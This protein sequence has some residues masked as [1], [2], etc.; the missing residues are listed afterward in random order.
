VFVAAPAAAG[1]LNWKLRGDYSYNS[2]ATCASASS[3]F[4][5]DLFFP[6]RKGTDG[7][8]PDATHPPALG[9]SYTY[10]IQGEFSFNGHGVFDFIKGEVLG[11]ML[12][13]YRAS[14][15]GLEVDTYSN[16]RSPVH[17]FYAQGTGVYAVKNE[18]DKLFVEIKF[19]SFGIIGTPILFKGT[20]FRGRLDT[21]TG[22]SIV[23]L[24][25]TTPI[26]EEVDASFYPPD[27][28]RICNATGSMVKLSPWKNWFSKE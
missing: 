27:M 25:T 1:D 19:D 21:V 17:H 28:Q 4:T 16:F 26:R 10:A 6:L 22:T 14:P 12:E 13:P 15:V 18:A 3:G 7:V 5:D 24:S 8:L 11:I 9:I 20:T 2:T 23:F